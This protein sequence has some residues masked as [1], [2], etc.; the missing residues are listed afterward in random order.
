MGAIGRR[1]QAAPGDQ[2][3]FN[4]RSGLISGFLWIHKAASRARREKTSAVMDGRTAQFIEKWKR[5]RGLVFLKFW[6]RQSLSCRRDGRPAARR[7][8]FADSRGMNAVHCRLID[9]GSPSVTRPLSLCRWC[10][11]W[12]HGT[13]LSDSGRTRGRPAGGFAVSAGPESCDSGDLD[14]L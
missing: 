2:T 11:D 13:Q 7:L 5:A 4:M 1:R 9:V 14:S 8:F 12:P 10:Q 3:S 6:R